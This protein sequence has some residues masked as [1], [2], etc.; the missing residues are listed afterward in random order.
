MNSIEPAAPHD[1]AVAEAAD[2]APA[3]CKNCDAV[4]LGRFCVNCSQAANVHVPTTMEL[5]H[6][7]LEG[8]T[9]SD[10]RLW[11]TLTTL[12]FKPGKLTAEF[13]AGRRV[14]YL[15]PFR[16]YLI[17]SIVFFLLTS[18]VRVDLQVVS[19]DEALKPAHPAAGTSA[20][21]AKSITSCADAVFPLHPAWNPRI[22]RTCEALQGDKS[23]NWVHLVIATL[24]KAMFIFLP[25]IAFLNMLMY[26]RPRYRYAEQLL[27]FVHLHAFY[28]SVA[29][30]LLL[31]N[32][33]ADSWPKFAGVAGF[34]STILGWTLPVYSLL[35]LRRVFPRSWPGTLFKGFLLFFVYSIVFGLTVAGVFVYA[36]LQL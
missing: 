23:G 30:L 7:L 14:A 10:S 34:L 32:E 5:V 27:F 35:A 4:L 2:V 13:V 1:V 15:P 28:F 26:W 24:P 36:A 18:F 19:F 25:L 12:W 3:R 8:I 16:L 11:R 20:P 31:I 33:G 29:I 6:E 21:A 17:L 22:R 9:H